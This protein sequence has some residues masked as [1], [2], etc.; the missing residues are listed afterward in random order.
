MTQEINHLAYL[1]DDFNCSFDS[2]DIVLKAYKKV[3]MT[4]GSV[5]FSIL[6]LLIADSRVLF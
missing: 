1:V 5:V 3:M 2:H 6:F 4:S